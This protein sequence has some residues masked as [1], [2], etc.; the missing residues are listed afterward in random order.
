MPLLAESTYRA[1][2]PFTS[3]HLNTIYAA[4]FRQLPTISYQRETIDTP[5]GDFLDLDWQK[6][7]NNRLLIGLH[8]LEGNADRP[9]L[10]GMFRHFGKNGWDT[11]GMNFRSCSGRM[12]RSLRMYNMGETH[13]LS[14]VI[15]H[16]LQ[17]HHYQEIALTGFS[18][19][20]N[21][22]LKYMGENGAY[23][24]REISAAVAF[25]VPCDLPSANVAIGHWQNKIYL[26]RFL[27]TLNEKVKT[28]SRLFPEHIH[29]GKHLP[30]SFF[31]FDDR[32]TGPIHGYSGAEDYWQSCSSVPFLANIDRPVLLVSALDDTF[33]GGDCFPVGL[34]EKHPYFHLETP[35]HGGHC[36]FYTAGKDGGWWAEQRALQF[37]EA[38]QAQ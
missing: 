10:R 13:D 2:W 23:V 6:G 34:A 17:N 32:Y 38:K 28:K 29:T 36:G 21:V 27:D 35:K 4:I 5:D 9:Y 20:G 14:L 30:R 24:P 16:V 37:I 12:N 7:K 8:G 26:K 15:Q 19:G 25:S 18:L 1:P 11:L 22:V 3:S 33:L 31:E